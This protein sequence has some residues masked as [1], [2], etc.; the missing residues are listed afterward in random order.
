MG[1]RLSSIPLTLRLPLMVA[2]LMS[3]VGLAASAAVLRALSTAQASQLRTMA[4]LEFDSIRT[5]AMSMLIRDDTW[6]LFDLL[7]RITQRG[8]GLRP[9]EAHLVDPYGRVIVSTQPAQFR[10]GSDGRHL[11]AE[12]I[13]LDAP[14]Y[15]LDEDRILLKRVVEGEGRSFGQLVV[16]F[17]VGALLLE[18]KR[19]LNWLVMGNLAATLVLALAGYAIALRAMRPISR[20]IHQM[21]IPGGAPQPIPASEIP[22]GDTETARLYRS[23]NRM[24][25][26]VEDRNAAERRLADRE[27]FVSLGRLAGTMA[28]EVNNP[29]GGLLNAVDTLRSFPDRPEVVARNADLLDRGLKHLR[30]VVRVTLD[31]HRQARGDVPLQMVD[32]EDLHALIRPEADR[33]GQTLIWEVTAPP[34]AFVGLPA[35]PVRQVVLNLLLNASAVSGKGGTFG[36]VVQ[37][38][39]AGIAIVIKDSGAGLPN[40]LRP[41]LLSDDPIEPGGGLGLRL[42]REL[43]VGLGGTVSLGQ[44][45]SGLQEVIVVLTCRREKTKDHAART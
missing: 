13:L 32:F 15:P 43:V 16:G 40:E 23:Y 24:L 27:R 21:G 3:L 37:S 25:R 33:R 5:S 12:A 9:I 39:D 45:P 7:D 36:L 20:L 44:S 8:T 10:I 4:E 34:Q 42:V 19:T 6:E 38:L 29:L 2:V 22:V 14:D 26:A 28:H 35:G 41:R 18:R 11:I 1:S 30:D 31:T 17:D